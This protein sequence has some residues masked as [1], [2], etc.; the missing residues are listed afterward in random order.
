MT[1]ILKQ[2][3]NVHITGR[4][5][6]I[7]LKHLLNIIVISI[8][9][10]CCNHSYKL[11][12]TSLFVRNQDMIIFFIIHLRIRYNDNDFNCCMVFYISCRNITLTKV[13]E[14]HSYPFKASKLKF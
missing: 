4:K 1:I 10:M 2:Y 3:A 9:Q 6:K 11:H 8:P 12:R 5:K 14:K 13:K 7:L